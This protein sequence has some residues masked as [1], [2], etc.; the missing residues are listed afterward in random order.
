MGGVVFNTKS[1][2]CKGAHEM[3]A[4]APLLAVR[5]SLPRKYRDSCRRQLK[6]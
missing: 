1:M 6:K 3:P 5:L 4:I 2:I